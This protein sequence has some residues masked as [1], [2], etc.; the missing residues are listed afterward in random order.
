MIGVTQQ[1][2]IVFPHVGMQRRDG[3]EMVMA[4]LGICRN[5][6]YGSIPIMR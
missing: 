5:G 6:R 2:F 1:R 4:V 3:W